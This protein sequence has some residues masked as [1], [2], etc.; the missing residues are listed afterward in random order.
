MTDYHKEN[1][2]LRET[3][4][5]LNGKMKTLMEQYE[6]RE[7]VSSWVHGAVRDSG[8]GWFVGSWNSTRFGNRLVRGFMEQYDFWEQISFS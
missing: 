7:Q 6:I 4:I 3:N 8:T 2:K 1:T 5:E